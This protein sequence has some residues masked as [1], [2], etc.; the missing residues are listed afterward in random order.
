M[1]YTFLLLYLSWYFKSLYFEM[2]ARMKYEHVIFF[3]PE[4]SRA[5]VRLMLK[6]LHNLTMMSD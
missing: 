3:W 4:I 6:I 1:R 2:C 5:I